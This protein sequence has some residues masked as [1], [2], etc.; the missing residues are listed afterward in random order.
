MNQRLL[1]PTPHLFICMI[2]YYVSYIRYQTDQRHF[3]CLSTAFF[4][5]R[6]IELHAFTAMIDQFCIFINRDFFQKLHFIYTR[7]VVQK[8]FY[9]NQRQKAFLPQISMMILLNKL[10]HTI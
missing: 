7:L 4:C 1:P 6:E 10:V 8:R 3:T 9:A 5:S 2:S